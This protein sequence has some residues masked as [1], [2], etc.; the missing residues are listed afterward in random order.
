MLR[1]HPKSIFSW[2]FSITKGSVLVANLT[3]NWMGERGSLDV[4]GA[5]YDLYRQGWL[6]GAFVIATDRLVVAQAGKSSPFVRRFDVAY[7]HHRL[8]L[9]ARSPFT[10]AFGVYDESGEIGSIYPDHFLTR[11]ATIALPESIAL[12]VQAFLFW[13]AVLMWRRAANSSSN[14]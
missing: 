13:L 11:R 1:A 14:S 10:R 2:N 4:H 8:C 7:G 9:T 12:P 5:R 3:M 6:H